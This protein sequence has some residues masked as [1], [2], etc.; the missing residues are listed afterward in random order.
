MTKKCVF[1]RGQF[2]LISY[3]LCCC[4]FKVLSICPDLHDI[5]QLFVAFK[6]CILILGFAY[7][8]PY[9]FPYQREYISFCA[10]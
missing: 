7:W 2:S 8:Y 6:I 10:L 4:R 3:F 1:G 9:W 5:D